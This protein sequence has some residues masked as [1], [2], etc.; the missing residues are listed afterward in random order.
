MPRIS[1]I[2]RAERR[3]GNDQPACRTE[4]SS[5]H[6]TQ[7]A[8]VTISAAPMFR[9]SWWCPPCPGNIRRMV[10]RWRNLR[11][12][13]A[14]LM[15]LIAVGHAQLV[16]ACVATGTGSQRGPCCPPV[17]EAPEAKGD[18]AGSGDSDRASRCAAALDAI[19]GNSLTGPG[20]SGDGSDHHGLE[21]ISLPVWPTPLVAARLI[22]PPV[23]PPS[24][25]PSSPGTRTYLA[26]LRLR[27]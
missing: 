19:S 14:L 20:I 8:R 4:S 15:A 21:L 23:G 9:R 25:G 10:R 12:V 3:R 1:D 13:A 6:C 24:A 18:C 11:D 17:I 2:I 27:L 22:P 5:P 7:A 16:Y 26:T